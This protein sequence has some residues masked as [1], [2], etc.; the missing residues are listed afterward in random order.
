MEEKL[1]REALKPK[2]RQAIRK[3]KQIKVRDVNNTQN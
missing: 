2:T 1:G 3:V